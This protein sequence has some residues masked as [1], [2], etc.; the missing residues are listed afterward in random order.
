MHRY[1]K[2]NK[3]MTPVNGWHTENDIRSILEYEEERAQISGRSPSVVIF[4]ATVQIFGKDEKNN[5]RQ[6]FHQIISLVTFF[7]RKSDIK[8][9][10]ND[11]KMGVILLDTKMTGAK[12]YQKRLKQILTEYFQRTE[13]QKYYTFFN[14]MD[15]SNFTLNQ[16]K[17]QFLWS[18][19]QDSEDLKHKSRIV[20]F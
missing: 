4:D 6:F 20:N 3:V 16:I 9:L 11:Q 18:S 17:Q 15:I 12:A 2:L 14:R 8:Y 10:L 13:Y 7:S 5:Y 19:P 1:Y